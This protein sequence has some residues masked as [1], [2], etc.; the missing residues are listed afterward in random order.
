[1]KEQKISVIVPVYKVESYLDQC[2]A[3][4]VNQTYQN[5]EIILVDD[6]S[7]DNCFAMC[8]RWAKKDTRIKV[9]HQ[10]NS[11]VSAA[12]NAG[13]SMATG[14]WLMFVDSDDAIS[15]RLTEN[16][17]AASEGEVYLPVA[18]WQRFTDKTPE[19]NLAN[20]EVT[21]APGYQLAKLRGGLYIF[22]ALYNR[23]LVKQLSLQFDTNLKNLEDVVWNSIYLRYVESV[24]FISE[25]LYYYRIN[26][27]SITSQ[28]IDRHWQVSSWLSARTAILNWF[29]DKNL[30]TQQKNEVLKMYRHCQNN[31]YAECL[32]GNISYRQ[33][34]QL[35]LSVTEKTACN[36]V[37]LHQMDRILKNGIP[38]LY[39][40]G[41][42]LLLHLHRANSRKARIK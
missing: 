37:L 4:I 2:V 16:L 10:E 35:E 42:L 38:W 24:R 40:Q 32:T 23:N 36:E 18:A 27:T 19:D 31:I 20:S 12:R 1:M 25:P 6:G 26:P 11:G 17:L 28:C 5:L 8:D 21:V 9:I 13:I 22:A 30:S 14:E 29:A 3:S 15:T 33:Y 7:P 34:R 39:Y 41:Y